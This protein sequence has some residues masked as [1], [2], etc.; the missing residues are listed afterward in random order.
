V[1]AL[2]AA[3]AQPGKASTPVYVTEYNTNWAFYQDCCKNHPTYA[4]LF[5]ALYLTDMLDTVY[6]ALPQMTT[7]IYYY[8]G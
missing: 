1:Q 6:N 2:V 4:P 7:K 8:S 5:N 3:G